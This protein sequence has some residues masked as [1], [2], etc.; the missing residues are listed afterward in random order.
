VVFQQVFKRCGR[1]S[2]TAGFLDRGRQA[3][4]GATGAGPRPSG[5]NSQQQARARG[6]SIGTAGR[7]VALRLAPVRRGS[8]RW[9][10]RSTQRTSPESARLDE[11]DVAAV[12]RPGDV[13]QRR[14]ARARCNCVRSEPS[15]TR[16]KTSPVM[17]PGSC[18][19][20]LRG[21]MRFPA[22]RNIGAAS[23]AIVGMLRCSSSSSHCRSGENARHR[24]RRRV[25][26]VDD[27][28]RRSSIRCLRGKCGAAQKRE[29]EK[30]E[31]SA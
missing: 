29:T 30:R 22:R 20:V 1:G 21:L 24:Q 8:A 26:N 5:M 15:A 25:Q 16:F 28:L 18:G 12:G 9:R 17:P 23:S 6:A 19:P 7:F 14:G 4:C 13:R 27:D 10:R 2:A 11:G 3:V 31:A